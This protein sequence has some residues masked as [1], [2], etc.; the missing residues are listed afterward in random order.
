MRALASQCD[1]HATFAL[2]LNRIPAQLIYSLNGNSAP[3]PYSCGV[4]WFRIVTISY[5][6]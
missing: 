5:N 4:R 2:L 3:V 6:A 1:A